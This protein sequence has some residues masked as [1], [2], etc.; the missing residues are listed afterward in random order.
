[1]ANYQMLSTSC[2]YILCRT[3]LFEMRVPIERVLTD[4]VSR[5]ECA[6][7]G[8]RARRRITAFTCWPFHRGM[9]NARC[10][11]SLL[12]GLPAT[13]PSYDFGVQTYGM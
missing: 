9:C 12:E 4:T 13:L 11:H 5:T 1:M 3:C 7:Q 10:I 8:Q 6:G 2:A